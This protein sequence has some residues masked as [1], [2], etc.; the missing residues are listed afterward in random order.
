MYKRSTTHRH[1]S[2]QLGNKETHLTLVYKQHSIV[3]SLELGLETKYTLF[4]AF[5]WETEDAQEAEIGEVSCQL[6]EA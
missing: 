5:G 4:R 6:Q 1:T 3:D 2:S